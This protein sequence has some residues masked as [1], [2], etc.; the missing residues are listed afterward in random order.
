[1]PFNLIET[2]S[3]YF[4]PDFVNQASSNLGESNSGI[5][6]ALSAI[7]PTGLA[8]IMKKATSGPEGETS[9][10]NMASE[11]ALG[12]PS[13]PA[14][15]S[16]ASHGT[17]A[18]QGNLLTSLFSGNQT[19]IVS[20]IAGFAGIKN[21]TVSSL[22]SMGL[23][24]IMGLLGK[25]AKQNNLSANGLS[26]FLA[27]QK[28]NI[29]SAMPAGL[30]S[31]A[32]MFGLGSASSSFSSPTPPKAHVVRRAEET[33]DEGGGNKWLLPLII[34]LVAIGLL[35]YFLRGCNDTKEEVTSTMPAVVTSTDTMTT[36]VTTPVVTAPESI[37][38]K[39]P[40][41][42]ELDAN[43][44]GIEDQLVTF[45]TGNWKGMSEDALK[46]KWFDFDNLNFNTGKATLLPESERQLKNIAEILKA[47]PDAK[48]KIGGYTDAS[49]NAI[50]N[51][52]L[53]Q[54]RADAAKAGL[55]RLGVSAQVLEAE[56]YGSEFAKFPADASEEQREL[57]R[58]VS[59]SVRK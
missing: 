54:E 36:T 39:L 9:I 7:I 13:S 40:N 19:G 38:V 1:M 31:L 49:G 27:S 46:E 22:L 16:L 26:G 43:R 45:L 59:V 51:K 50:A 37:K 47:F 11:S 21:A 10:F 3:N 48:I 2:V 33:I 17:P 30:S 32:G 14:F 44:G 34:A 56:G 53:S 35:W 24:V 20:A 18:A 55:D 52:K 41:G 42:K 4:T 12:L 15:D 29:M 57:D 58:H 5:S 28:D 25:H 23:P 6:K 8:G